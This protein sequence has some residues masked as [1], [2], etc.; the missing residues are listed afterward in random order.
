MNTT[1]VEHFLNAA[2]IFVLGGVLLSATGYQIITGQSPC[3]LCFLQRLGMIGIA[4]GCMLNLRFG[5]KSTHYG[6]VLLFACLG[7]GISL[8]QIALHV[9]PQFP[10]FGTPVLGYSLFTWA[11]MVFASS[12]LATSLLLFLRGTNSHSSK[13]DPHPG[14]LNQITYLFLVSIVL[15]EIVSAFLT[16]GLTPCTG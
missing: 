9:C 14:L 1:K 7:G 10:T 3:P 16:C 4:V 8:R 13:N 5:I 2:F 11:L 12:I 6:I 15:L